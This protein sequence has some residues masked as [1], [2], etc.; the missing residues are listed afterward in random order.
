MVQKS[1]NGKML[2][3]SCKEQNKQSYF[4]SDTKEIDRI[5]LKTLTQLVFVVQLQH[6]DG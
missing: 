4:V 6:Q 1:S 2:F 3:L 5:G